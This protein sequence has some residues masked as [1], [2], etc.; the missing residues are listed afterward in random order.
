MVFISPV[1]LEQALD[2]IGSLSSRRRKKVSLVPMLGFGE[3]REI[4]GP[5]SS[6]WWTWC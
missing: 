5:P 2:V 6:W 4:A 3:V 1:L